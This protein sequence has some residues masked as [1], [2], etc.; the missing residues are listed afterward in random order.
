MEQ[1]MLGTGQEVLGTQD[2]DAGDREKC[3]GH[4]TGGI[5]DTERAVLGTQ[6]RRFWGHT[7]QE[8]LGPWSRRLWGHGLE[9]PEDTAQETLAP[10]PVLPCPTWPQ[11]T[12]SRPSPP[13]GGSCP[14]LTT[15]PP[16]SRA[17]SA[18]PALPA[19]PARKAA[20]DPAVRPAPPAAPE[21]RDPPDPPDPLAR[22]ELLVLM[23]PL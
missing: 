13:T 15:S 22:K 8:V 12:P 14:D 6:A 9:G 2:R 21:N 10:L 20:K 17:T 11:D 19:P 7:E 16:S 18:S 23:V 1:E 3:W 4:G 5:G